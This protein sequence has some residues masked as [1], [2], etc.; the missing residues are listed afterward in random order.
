VD[1]GL[2][3]HDAMA[4]THQVAFSPHHAAERHFGTAIDVGDHIAREV[5]RR[6]RATARRYGIDDPWIVDV[7]AGSGRLLRQLL[8][9]GHPPDRLL[10][11]D[12]RPAPDLPV[13]WIQGVAP[14]AVPEVAGLLLAH[15]FLDDIPLDV[16]R[17]GHVLTTDGRPGPP[18]TQ[19]QC[20]W[21][22]RWGEG[23]CGLTRDDAWAALVSRVTVGQAIAVDYPRSLPVGHRRGRRMPAVAD[24]RTDISAGVEFRSLRDRTGGRLVP[25]HRVLPPS[26]GLLRDRGSFGSFLWLITDVPARAA[27]TSRP[28]RAH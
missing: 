13:H 11:V 24:G 17:D 28:S 23:P 25:Q 18:A 26:A 1:E 7:G 3:W 5:L 19:A 22:A 2:T 4:W 16:V 15:E 21:S 20:A 10:G 9:L 14:A 12:V 27:A 8:D 6:C